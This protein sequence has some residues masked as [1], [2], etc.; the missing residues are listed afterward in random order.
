STASF[1]PSVAVAVDYGVQGRDVRFDR[2]A[3]YLIGSVILSW[4]LFAGGGDIAR[5]DEARSEASRLRALRRDAAD[6]VQLEVL[7]AFDAAVVA[8]GA[9]ETAGDRLESARRAYELVRR[10]HEEG[11]ASLI[12]LIDARTA[13]TGAELNRSLTEYRYAMRLVELERAAALRDV[14][15]GRRS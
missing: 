7:Q 10:R 9:I 11:V 2:S 14:E 3:D 13:L 5:R 15:E 6:R 8:R 1:L 12:E 4:H